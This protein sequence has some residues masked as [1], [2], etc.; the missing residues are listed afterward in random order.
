MRDLEAKLTLL[1]TTTSSLQ[2]DNERLK[3]MLQKAKA[4]NELLR[5]SAA[6]SPIAAQSQQDENNALSRSWSGHSSVSEDA[7]LDAISAAAAAS[8]ISSSSSPDKSISPSQS[9][10]L[11]ASAT[12]DLIQSHPR[13]TAGSVDITK[14]YE[15]L[16]KLARTNGSGPMFDE[17]EVRKVIDEVG[18][19]GA[20]EL[21]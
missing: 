4:E 2:S 15:R 7:S 18:G 13:Y 14:V 10:L 12:W 8:S 5:A 16:R 1:T 6:T 17:D 11:S 3:V 9:T 20:D 19:N 21:I